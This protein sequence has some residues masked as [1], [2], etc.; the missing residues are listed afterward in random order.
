MVRKTSDMALL[1]GS[2]GRGRSR[3]GVGKFLLGVWETWFGRSQW[4]DERSRRSLQVP[5][6]IAAVGVLA[7]FASG[8]LLGG[9]VGGQPP[10]GGAGLKANNPATPSFVGEFDARPMARKAFLVAMYPELAEADAKASAK[11]LSDWLAG[12]KLAKARPYLAQGR[13]GP[14]WTV[15]VYFE[16]HEQI[17]TR[18]LLLGLPDQVPDA[19]FV[20]LRK[21]EPEWPKAWDIR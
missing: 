21:N 10:G 19:S 14:V 15:A 18:D 6:W 9:K 16:D 4:R 2:R 7:A 17:A 20:S 13:K 12:Q 3:S 11:A 1:L 5:G 8:W